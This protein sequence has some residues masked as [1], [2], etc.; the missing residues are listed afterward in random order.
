MSHEQPFRLREKGGFPGVSP[1]RG[2][3]C[4]CARAGLQPA[5]W[6][7]AADRQPEGLVVSSR[8]VEVAAGDRHP[9]KR[10]PCESQPEGLLVIC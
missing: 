1:L 2:F 6:V 7:G 5:E 9:R 8:G 4:G 10:C 3:T